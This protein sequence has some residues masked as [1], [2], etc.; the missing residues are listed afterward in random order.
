MLRKSTTPPPMALIPE[1]SD[2]DDIPVDDTPHHDDWDWDDHPSLTA[3]ERN[4]SLCR[5]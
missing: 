3:S 1:V 4:P 2:D 5:Q